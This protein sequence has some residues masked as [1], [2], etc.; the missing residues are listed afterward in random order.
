[1]GQELSIDS[2]PRRLSALGK[3]RY[4]EGMEEHDSAPLSLPSPRSSEVEIP[5]R[6]K[7]PITKQIMQH[8][9]QVSNGAD[10]EEA[11]I[12]AWFASSGTCTAPPDQTELGSCITVAND[13]LQREIQSFLE[14]HPHLAPAQQQAASKQLLEQLAQALNRPCSKQGVAAEELL[15]HAITRQPDGSLY[16]GKW[17]NGKREGFGCYV[18][19]DRSTYLGQFHNDHYSGYGKFHYAE[20]SS[21]DG[22]WQNAHKHGRGVYLFTDGSEYRGEF[23]HNQYHGEG[24]YTCKSDNEVEV[25]E[26]RWVKNQLNGQGTYSKAGIV[27]YEGSWKAGKREGAGWC[28]VGGKE[29]SWKYEGEWE[30]GK[31]HGQGKLVCTLSQQVLYRGQWHY[32]VRSGKGTQWFQTDLSKHSGLISGMWEYTGDWKEDK[33]D[34]EGKLQLMP[35][36]AQPG[37]GGFT[38]YEGEFVQDQRHGDGEETMTDGSKHEGQFRNNVYQG[39]NGFCCVPNAC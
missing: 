15:H 14:L 27:L 31:W 5:E 4:Q 38:T 39:S 16:Q 20:G 13:S 37:G 35:S 1:M 32:G 10:F 3:V 17:E 30:T 26:G 21:Y 6:F 7:C 23:V 33:W 24:R 9:V 22:Q 2:I 36:S 11:A 12:Q 19:S 28:C 18:H 25:Y 8:P 29:A 34:G